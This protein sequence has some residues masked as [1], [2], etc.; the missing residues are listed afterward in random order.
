MK[1]EAPRATKRRD[2]NTIDT[3]D[4]MRKCCSSKVVHASD[5][6]GSVVAAATSHTKHTRNT[7][8]ESRRQRRDCGAEG[9]QV[10]WFQVPTLESRNSVPDKDN[11][12]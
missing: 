4:A 8:T 2:S 1:A 5:A 3:A 9:L 12:E 10:V 6:L 11:G 7:M